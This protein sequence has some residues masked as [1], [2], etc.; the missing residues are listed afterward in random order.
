MQTPGRTPEQE[1]WRER[2]SAAMAAYRSGSM[3][4]AAASLREAIELAQAV[5]EHCPELATTYN[6][7]AAV[8]ITTVPSAGMLTNNGDV[9]SA[10][11]LIPVADITGGKLVFTPK[12][13]YVGGPFFLCKFQVQDNGGVIGGGVDLDPTPKILYIKILP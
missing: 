12:V 6:T 9:V 7:L 3:D 1:R 4:D 2:F 11:D 13:N 5:G 10:G 8:E